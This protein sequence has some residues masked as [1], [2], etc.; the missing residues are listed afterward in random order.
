[1]SKSSPITA[2]IIICSSQIELPVIS[3]TS[4]AAPS[5]AHL[6]TQ[7]RHT[8]TYTLRHTHASPT[9]KQ[10]MSRTRTQVKSNRIVSVDRQRVERSLLFPSDSREGAGERMGSERDEQAEGTERIEP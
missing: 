9:I 5:H 4:V 3:N 8:H 6:H 2:Q 7:T 1:M 10:S